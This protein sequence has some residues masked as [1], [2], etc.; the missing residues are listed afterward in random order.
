MEIFHAHLAKKENVFIIF[1]LPITLE[2]LYINVKIAKWAY[3]F[4]KKEHEL[5]MNSNH[6]F[7]SSREVKRVDMVRIDSFWSHKSRALTFYP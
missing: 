5:V 7:R 4:L 2:T 6:V 1:F 3:A